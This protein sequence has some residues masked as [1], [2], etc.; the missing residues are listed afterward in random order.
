M[1][2]VRR[3]YYLRLKEQTSKELQKSVHA[4]QIASMSVVGEQSPLGGQA[5]KQ[6]IG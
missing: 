5:P 6:K 3:Q 2:P 4:A 1:S